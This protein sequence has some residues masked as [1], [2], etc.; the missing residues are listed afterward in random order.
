MLVLS[1]LL[2]RAVKKENLY[3]QKELEHQQLLDYMESL[4][5]IN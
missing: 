3:I 5:R 4:E 1:F 2:T